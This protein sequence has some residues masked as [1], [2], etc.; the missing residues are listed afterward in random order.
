M[1]CVDKDS[2]TAYCKF[3]CKTC[4]QRTQVSMGFLQY[5]KLG[6]HELGTSAQTTLQYIFAFVATV[7]TGVLLNAY[8]VD[9]SSGLVRATAVWSTYRPNVYFGVKAKVP[10][11]PL[12]GMM[13]YDPMQPSFLDSI[14]HDC[15]ARDE[16]TQYGYQEHDGRGYASQLLLD[17]KMGVNI[18]TKFIKW[19]QA[20]GQE[21]FSVRVT[22]TRPST[23]SKK[24]LKQE[25]Y[26]AL[27][28]YQT[29]EDKQ[30]GSLEFLEGGIPPPVR[31]RRGGII[32][33]AKG[34]LTAPSI[35]TT[36]P[37]SDIEGGLSRFQ[38]HVRGSPA[39]TFL[40]P[41]EEL[42]ERRRGKKHPNKNSK[43]TE[44]PQLTYYGVKVDPDYVWR[45]KAV[46]NH[47]LFTS[48]WQEV[49]QRAQQDNPHQRLDM[50]GYQRLLSKYTMV[51]RLPNT[52]EKGANVVMFQQIFKLP[53]SLDIDMVALDTHEDPG[54]LP[55]LPPAP[56]PVKG[57][58]DE[59]EEEGQEE[60]AVAEKLSIASDSFHFK[61]SQTFFAHHPAT[62]ALSALEQERRQFAEAALSNLLG[63]IGYYYGSSLI[64]SRPGGAT[65]PQET[66]PYG[67]LTASP[68]RSFFPRGFLWDE[69]FHQLLVSRWDVKLTL[70]V[71]S[72]WLALVDGNGW[73]PREQIVGL[74]ARS[75]VPDQ[76]VVQTPEVF[77][78]PTFFL[79]FESLIE[80]HGNATNTGEDDLTARE[81]FEFLHKVFPAM[82]RWTHAFS[83]HQA[84]VLPH[85]YK[86]QR[87]LQHCLPSG[88]DDYPR[89]TWL[90]RSEGHVDLHSWVV[91][92]TRSMARIAHWLAG[93]SDAADKKK[94]QRLSVDFS[95][96]QKVEE[97]ALVKHHWDEETGRFCDYAFKK[98]KKHYI[99][100]DGYISLFPVLLGVLP[101]S[102]S[103][104]LKTL[105][106]LPSEK[107]GI[108][109]PWGL[110][111]LSVHDKNYATE[112]NYWR[113]NIWINVNYLA[114]S[115]LKKYGDASSSTLGG[116]LTE[117]EEAVAQQ[118]HTQ[119]AKLHKQLKHN[120]IENMFSNYQ[121]NRKYIMP[122]S[123][124]QTACFI[125]SI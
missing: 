42:E 25:Q 116:S 81:L 3:R 8:L 32:Q 108:W 123:A 56:P 18:T 41:V 106:L 83:T 39:N 26:T 68:S 27:I 114:V 7:V 51:P 115:A 35:V 89:C 57:E 71:L 112:E 15:D 54:Y 59:L 64:A 104:V 84:A 50:E 61:F 65:A 14:R 36:A 19:T 74:E 91:L 9:H 62:E 111:S 11:S 73:L 21:R 69:G 60:D 96:R 45:T 92:M 118:V 2:L 63:G 93:H 85:S 48:Y 16:L 70:E 20:D 10:S 12:L 77:N 122:V 22:G 94:Y 33:H 72:D 98:N 37:L 102:S 95:D 97:E 4:T 78:P 110:R 90:A 53:F 82:Q 34:V 125:F 43:A 55:Q 17:E 80:R 109:T 24:E 121:A 103:L 31:N 28:W 46:L 66:K 76:F 99:C 44:A 75:R 30:S 13:W 58:E 49:Q 100:H 79:V 6:W 88:L 120:V 67:L 52:I 113:G 5:A 107:F 117:E 23:L 47:T 29:I 119:S 87:S 86:W 105:Q 1:G 40:A 38:V 124:V 101:P